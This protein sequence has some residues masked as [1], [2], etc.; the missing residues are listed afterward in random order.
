MSGET[1]GQA[2]GNGETPLAGMAKVLQAGKAR[3]KTPL[4]QAKGERGKGKGERGK[5]K[6]ERRK[7]NRTTMLNSGRA[8]CTVQQAQ[9]TPHHN[10]RIHL[11][12]QYN[13]S[14]LSSNLTS[15]DLPPVQLQDSIQ[16]FPSS[17][18]V[19]HRTQRS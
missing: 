10:T 15:R 12:N 9:S 19:A 2:F 8:S 14:Q 7:A 4:G 3:D 17:S 16:K 13:I 6:G 11:A 18:F 5:G 1:D